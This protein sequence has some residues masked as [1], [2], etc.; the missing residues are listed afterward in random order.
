MK[1]YELNQ[2][3]PAPGQPEAA[4]APASPP[5]P[6]ATLQHPAVLV[7][8]AARYILAA[9][10]SLGLVLLGILGLES[11]AT[12]SLVQ[13]TTLA[14]GFVLL[15]LAVDN[16]RARAGYLFISGIAVL[17]LALLS[18]VFVAELVVM[19]APVVALWLAVWLAESRR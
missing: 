4:G 8:P 5:G 19:A 17:T 3:N 7:L 12:A 1:H 14:C 15:A 16:S 6:R 10:L 11:P 18:R 2:W 9:L 13:A